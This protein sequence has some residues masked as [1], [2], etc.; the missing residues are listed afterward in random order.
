LLFAVPLAFAVGLGK[1]RSAITR[2]CKRFALSCAAAALIIAPVTLRN[3][4]AGGELVL[5]TDTG[6]L[7]FYIGNGPGAHG[8]F[9]V[10][11]ELPSATNAQRQFRVFRAAAE[12]ATQRPLS[13]RQVSAYWYRRTWQAIADDPS[14]WLRL[15]VE[16]AWLFWNGREPPN[17]YDYEFNRLINPLLNIAL[18]QFAWIAPLGLLGTLVMLMRR[19]RAEQVVALMVLT[20]MVALVLFFVVARY[21]IAAVP[22]VMIAAA[23][24]AHTLWQQL[25]NRRLKLAAAAI[26]VLLLG[27]WITTAPKLSKPFDDEYFKLGYA[28]HRAGALAHAEASYRQ[29]LTINDNNISAHKN[30]AQLYQS[31]GRFDA[32]IIHWRRVRALGERGDLP[33]YVEEAQEALDA[34]ESRAR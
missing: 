20:Q 23:V 16:K 29:A 34:I 9:R 5:I 1:D 19:R 8:S 27:V 21:R 17:T 15:L 28:Y 11:P 3:L 24:A 26:A 22:A 13:S 33:H 12:Q 18:V 31:I 32:A 30:L 2:A 4:L 10:P 14:T 6:G 7:N 25:R